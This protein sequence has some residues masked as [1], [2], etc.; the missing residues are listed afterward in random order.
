MNTENGENKWFHDGIECYTPW[1]PNV[2]YANDAAICNSEAM[3]A[4]TD[5]AFISYYKCKDSTKCHRTDPLDLA[6]GDDGS[7]WELIQAEARV[8]PWKSY[9]GFEKEVCFDYFDIIDGV[10]DYY[11]SMTPYMQPNICYKGN[12]YLCDLDTA[13]DQETGLP[14][15]L[16]TFPDESPSCEMQN[17]IP[18]DYKNFPEAMRTDYY[19]YYFKM[20]GTTLA[21]YFRPELYKADIAGA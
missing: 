7:I 14:M 1:L 2:V 10:F 20:Q 12:S 21:S 3:L 16:L 6:P 9:H 18:L 5:Y 11:I 13:D 4:G 17:K 8:K 15:S 19:S